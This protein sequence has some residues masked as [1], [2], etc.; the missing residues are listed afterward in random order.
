MGQLYRHMFTG[1][2]T[3]RGRSDLFGLRDGQVRFDQ[4]LIHNGGWFNKA[5]HY[6]G[7][8]DLSVDDITRIADGLKEGEVFIVLR[9]T[10]ANQATDKADILPFL[11]EHTVFAIIQG[12]VYVTQIPRHPLGRDTILVN[13]NQLYHLF[14]RPKGEVNNPLR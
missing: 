3:D 2:Q 9:E 7:L 13:S 5:G 11:A 6:L 14:T 4:K 8:G 1:W 10:P 12:R